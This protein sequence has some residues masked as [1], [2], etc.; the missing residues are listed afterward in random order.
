M[1]GYNAL[2]GIPSR[3]VLLCQELLPRIDLATVYV[4]ALNPIFDTQ[5]PTARVQPAR[6]GASTD[7]ISAR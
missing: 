3:T 4:P 5:P 1:R 6:P 2:L 7:K